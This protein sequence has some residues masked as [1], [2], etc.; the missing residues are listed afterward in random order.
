MVLIWKPQSLDLVLDLV[1]ASLEYIVAVILSLI[2]VGHYQLQIHC[3]KNWR[4]F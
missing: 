3:F 1:N 4:L 2:I